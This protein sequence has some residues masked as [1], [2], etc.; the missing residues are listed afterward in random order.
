MIV[1]AHIPGHEFLNKGLRDLAAG[2]QTEEAL[3]VLIGA[4][5][6]RSLLPEAALGAMAL[7]DTPEH[8]LFTKL[9]DRLGRG[10]HSA[11]NALIRRLVSAE[12][13]LS[14]SAKRSEPAAN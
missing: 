8:L 4:P 5:R 2:Q 9:E 3:L 13:A 12:N 7:S 11:Y 1:P 10:A 6:L 14:S